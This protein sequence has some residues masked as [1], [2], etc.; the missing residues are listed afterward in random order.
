MHQDFDDGL[1]KPA[2]SEQVVDK[3]VAGLFGTMSE[4]PVHKFSDYESYLQAAS[5]K[6]YASWKAC[7]ITANSVVDTPWAI[8]GPKGNEIQVRPLTDVL[9]MPNHCDTLCD[10][11]YETVMHLKLVGNSFWYKSGLN[12]R[13]QPNELYILNPK[14]MQIIAGVKQKVVGYKY[15]IN[16]APLYF[17]FDEIIH[18]KRPHPD[19]EYWGLGDIEASEPLHN[20]FLNHQSASENFYKNGAMPSGIMSNKDFSG[21]EE[22]LRK[23]KAKFDQRYNSPENAGKTAFITGDWEYHRLGVTANEAKEIEKTKLTIEQIYQVHGVPMEVAGLTAENN[24]SAESA[25]SRFKSMTVKPIVNII[26][27]RLNKDLVRSYVRRGKI[28]FSIAGLTPLG[29]TI[30]ALAPAIDRA[31]MTP[32][33]ARRMLG[34]RPAIDN[35]LGDQFLINAAL[36]P[37]EKAGQGP[38]PPNTGQL[39]APSTT[40]EGQGG[41]QNQES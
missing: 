30:E 7:D 18:F 15:M 33:E 12:S 4:I 17:T 5:R 10:L 25:K 22:D 13:L 24:K 27:D 20:G 36:L 31:M 21:T 37:A 32:N 38:Q 16:G 8:E 11:L 1:A 40:V 3:A 23:I 19:N 2:S 39:S 41:E 26:Q 34:L 28:V 29:E 9:D 14:H 35:P 6:L